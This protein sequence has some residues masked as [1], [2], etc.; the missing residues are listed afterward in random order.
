MRLESSVCAALW[1]NC[2]VLSNVCFDF[3]LNTAAKS[4]NNGQRDSS[5]DE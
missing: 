3:R 1:W 2:L 4:T 5:K